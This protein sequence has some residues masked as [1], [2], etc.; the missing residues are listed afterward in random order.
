MRSVEKQR[1]SNAY[2]GRFVLLATFPELFPRELQKR[3]ENDLLL[4]ALTN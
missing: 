1:T 4:D 3:G 2:A